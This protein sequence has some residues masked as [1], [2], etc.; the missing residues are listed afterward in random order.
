[1]TVSSGFDFAESPKIQFAEQCLLGAVMKVIGIGGAGCNAV[2]RMV[3]SGLLGVE[4]LAMNTDIQALNKCSATEKFPIGRL[5]T[6]G[7]GAGANPGIG[8]EAAEQDSEVI[9]EAVKGADLIFI[10]AGMG[11]GTGTG[12]AP[13][14]AQIAKEKKALTVA[15]VTKPFLFEGRMRMKIAEA[16]I[17]ELRKHVDTLIV[18]PNQRLLEVVN[19]NTSLLEAFQMADMV[20]TQATK[21]ISDLISKTGV[22]NLDFSD[23]KTVMENGGDALMGIGTGKGE[24][25]G[26]EAA[27][28]ALQ[29]PLLREISISGARNVLVNI[30]GSSAMS[31][32]EV[33]EAMNLIYETAGEN[34]NVIFG[35]VIDD[36][37]GDELRVTAIA[38]GFP[39][40]GTQ[41]PF[42]P[43]FAEKTADR[44]S[45]D[46]DNGF[47]L[48]DERKSQEPALVEV[49]GN[50]NG[51]GS[52]GPEEAQSVKRIKIGPVD[53][54][55]DPPTDMDLPSFLR[56]KRN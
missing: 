33:S 13:R 37:A 10:T 16:G 15:I 17:E 2:D 51:N 9:A 14:I 56:Q 1:M 19:P 52:K 34:S 38:T 28:E 7:R 46:S 27:L 43:L 29:C 22:V 32:H 5:L 48:D 40:D 50:G 45:G 24:D 49:D 6:R 55:A 36:N 25:R 20:L 44:G 31:L 30:S 41:R 35:A 3:A 26:R 21:G 39:S 4:F 11:G 47:E 53:M 42:R 12:A 23:V 18:I 8:R 54:D